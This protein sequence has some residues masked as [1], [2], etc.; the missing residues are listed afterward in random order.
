MLAQE[1]TTEGL[2]EYNK[3]AKRMCLP[4][5][6]QCVV[7]RQEEDPSINRPLG[8]YSKFATV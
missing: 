7:T 2:M 8:T 4:V 5:D 6:E 3:A 1:C